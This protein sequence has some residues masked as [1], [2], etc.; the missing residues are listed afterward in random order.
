MRIE[1]RL[2]TRPQGDRRDS[3]RKELHLRLTSIAGHRAASNVTVLDLSQTGV[4][5]QTSARLAAGETLQ[6]NLPHAGFRAAQVVWT[7]GEFVGCRFEQPISSAAISAAQLRSEP[8]AA[9]RS[10]SRAAI[11]SGA[12]A[13]DGFGARLRRLRSQY[14][15]SQSA[16]AKLVNVT[17]LSVW[18]WEH[19]DV[20]PRPGTVAALAN[21]FAVSESELLGGAPP[22]P[23][24]PA[25]QSGLESAPEGLAEII[26]GCKATIAAH[27][28]TTSDKVEITVNL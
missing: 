26:D 10:V 1:G 17:K 25:A 28:G 27:L 3:S 9:V 2:E 18:K 12:A 8:S 24:Q 14:N 19:G 4:L 5:L 16:L 15:L 23:D 13:G 22:P 20:R 7:S 11:E 6:I 21:L